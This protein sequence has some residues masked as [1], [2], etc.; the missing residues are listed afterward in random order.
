MI[1]KPITVLFLQ[2]KYDLYNAV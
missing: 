1:V 2:Q